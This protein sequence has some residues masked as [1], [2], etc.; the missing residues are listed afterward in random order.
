MK[1]ETKTGDKEEITKIGREACDG[2]RLIKHS[3]EDIHSA[4]Q[5]LT[6]KRK[7]IGKTDIDEEETDQ[8]T[9]NEE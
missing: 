3:K 1:R 6:S 5:A 9:G 7:K 8:E 2:T 4:T